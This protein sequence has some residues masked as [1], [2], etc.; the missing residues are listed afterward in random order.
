MID[1]FNINVFYPDGASPESG[2]QRIE[3][4]SDRWLSVCAQMLEEAGP[5]FGRNMGSTLSHFD[6]RMSGPIA[7]LA[8]YGRTCFNLAMTSGINAEQDVAT[9]NYFRGVLKEMATC[10]GTAVTD[11]ANES[12]DSSRSHATLLVL[13]RCVADVDDEQK[14]ALLQLGFHLVGAYYAFAE[15]EPN[16]G[17]PDD[18]RESPS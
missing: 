18:A 13:D 7:E 8:A 6:I 4:L 16:I 17:E 12:I 2:S 11:E 10:F 1:C 5:V 3:D 15:H 9:S 14:Q